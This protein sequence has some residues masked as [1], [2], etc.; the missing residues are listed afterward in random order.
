MLRIAP[1]LLSADFGH[2]ADQVQAAEAGGADYI[3]ID[4]MDGLF[5]PNITMG[6]LVVE[7]VRRATRLPLDVHLMIQ[8]PERYL[9]AFVA[10]GA[11]IL[12]I[13]AEACTHLQQALARIRALGARAGL[14]LCPATPLAVVE[15]VHEDLDLL[16][17]MTVNPGFGG[18]RLIP[19]TVGKVRR[20]RALLERLAASV[21]LEV[22]GGINP[23]TAPAVVAAGAET[24][25]AGSAVFNTAG[26]VAA[27]IAALRAAAERAALQHCRVG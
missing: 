18:Q 20:A 22:D 3:H 23:E 1:S 8:A 19:A 27:N 10:A 11:S 9:E 14:A 26:S 16:L 13:H 12:T 7:A 2:L 4:V 17:V 6:P 5:V 15:E 24:L 21:E 25:V